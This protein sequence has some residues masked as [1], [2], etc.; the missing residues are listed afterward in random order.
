MW[1][2]VIGGNNTYEVLAFI[3]IMMV[4]SV[5]DGSLIG[6]ILWETVWIALLA[7]SVNKIEQ[8]EEDVHH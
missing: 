5:S 2:T 6:I 3:S 8:E 4:A 1:Y 7:F